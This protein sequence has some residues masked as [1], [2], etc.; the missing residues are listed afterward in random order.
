M[1]SSE[2]E[3]KDSQEQSQNEEEQ[4]HEEEQSEGSDNTNSKSAS[5]DEQS[6]NESDEQS[7]ENEEDEE[8]EEGDE[9]EGEEEEKDSDPKSDKK[10]DD[11]NLK[12]ASEINIDLL[13][14]RGKDK[15]FLT[16]AY[17]PKVKTDTLSFINQIN[18][19]LEKLYTSLER[20][21]KTFSNTNSCD[22]SK[23]SKLSKVS[24]V[25]K[26]S[27]P[28]QT[29]KLSKGNHEKE[30]TEDDGNNN[31]IISNNMNSNNNKNNTRHSTTKKYKHENE[32]SDNN[33][34][35]SRNSNFASKKFFSDK[36][37]NTNTMNYQTYTGTRNF[38]RET[39]SSFKNSQMKYK[40][41]NVF[42]NNANRSN[43]NFVTMDDLYKNQPNYNDNAPVIYKDNAY[44]TNK[45]VGT[46]SGSGKLI[47]EYHDP[48]EVRDPYQ[49]LRSNH[50]QQFERQKPRNINQAMD[51]L[52]DKNY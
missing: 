43:Q 15:T 39:G 4:S 29:D 10:F 25:S 2:E 14:D 27:V 8:E 23:V 22:V 12:F 20:N 9:P 28:V 18:K 36:E 13:Q 34:R 50:K 17:S 30:D 51:I 37:T 21:I 16:S 26:K 1:S 11:K 5:N 42:L 31:E 49:S 45:G 7:E 32:L 38:N 24:K 3:R 35:S 41:S 47:R 52:L 44:N 19:D 40:P 46:Y 33:L 6:E 48:S